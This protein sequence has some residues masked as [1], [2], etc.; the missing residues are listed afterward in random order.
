MIRP[1]EKNDKNTRRAAFWLILLLCFMLN[2]CGGEIVG[3]QDPGTE[4]GTS[5]QEPGPDPIVLMPEASGTRVEENDKA[6]I[7][8]SHS[9]DGYIMVRFKQE[10]EKPL[11]VQVKI[12]ES[13]YIYNIKPGEWNVF[14]LSCGDGSYLVQCCENV[15]D[16]RYAVVLSAQID[17]VL[18]DEYTAFLRPNQYVDYGGAENT[19]AQASRLVTGK[20]AVLEKVNAVYSY[21][22]KNLSYDYDLAKNAPSGYLPDIDLVLAKKKGICFDYAA[23]MTAMLR[24]QGV[25][26]KLVIGYAG[27]AYHAWISVWC[28]EEGWMD[29]L[30]YFDGRTWKRMDPTF[31]STSRN[32]AETTKYIGDGSNYIEKFFY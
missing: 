21:I 24:S 26:C 3:N 1:S 32:R 29:K 25:P 9:E 10:T 30:I 4:P 15:E 27:D 31:A 7:D 6:V 14:P 23:L 19:L 22:T 20:S 16:R 5:S 11:K 12:G 8:H 18:N 2:A 13:N 28:A 17:A